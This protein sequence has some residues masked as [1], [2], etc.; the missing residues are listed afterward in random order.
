MDVRHSW[1]AVCKCKGDAVERRMEATCDG[2]AMMQWRNL[3][4]I[5]RRNPSLWAVHQTSRQCTRHRADT[6]LSTSK[7]GRSSTHMDHLWLGDSERRFLRK[8]DQIQISEKVDRDF[9]RR[10]APKIYRSEEVLTYYDIL[11]QWVQSYREK[12]WTNVWTPKEAEYEHIDVA[13]FSF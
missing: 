3:N 13:I 4:A 5:S 2:N 6:E 12:V 7:P 9:I 8:L 10:L 11:F 1:L